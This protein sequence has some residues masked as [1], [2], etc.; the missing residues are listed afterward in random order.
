[1]NDIPRPSKVD[2][3][4]KNLDIMKP[5]YTKHIN[6]CQS[7]DPL[8][9]RGSTVYKKNFK[10]GERGVINSVDRGHTIFCHQ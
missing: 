1:M 6:F 9:Y 7:T 10:F 2:K 4:E 5:P 3:K 8:L